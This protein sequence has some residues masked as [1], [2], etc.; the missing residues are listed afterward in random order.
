MSGF[1]IQRSKTLKC[2]LR[3]LLSC[4]DVLGVSRITE[5]NSYLGVSVSI[6]NAVRTNIDFSQVSS[7]QGKGFSL[8]Q[9]IV[10]ALGEAM[11]RYCAANIKNDR[12]NKTS[13]GLSPQG[14][15][16]D[17]SFGYAGAPIYNWI[18]GSNLSNGKPAWLPLQEVAFPYW[19]SA[20]E[21]IN[22]NA[23]TSGLAAG[24]T[25]EEAA[26][27]GLLEV[28]E[29]CVTSRFYQ[30]VRKE[31]NGKLIYPWSVGDVVAGNL[32]NEL[33]SMGCEILI[34][35]LAA[36]L[37][38]YYVAALD[39]Q[40]MSPKF[41]MAGT[42]AALSESDALRGA[43]LECVQGLVTGLQG[44]REDLSR[45]RN[46]YSQQDYTHTNV[47]YKVRDL[48]L[49]QNGIAPFFETAPKPLSTSEALSLTLTK[50]NGE[51]G[52]SVYVCDLSQQ[53]FPLSVV[54]VVA[55]SLND[56]LSNPRRYK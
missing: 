56:S 5:T 47:F 29:R 14:E 40:N 10:G 21:P 26:L 45:L 28:Y 41:M 16:P 54:K 36:L 19:R 7:T 22:I 32:I 9:A 17:L 35:R 25:F 8:A 53:N 48:L 18:L 4:R 15:A 3:S 23:Y 11:E 34:F 2:V 51:T 13:T 31:N 12:L 39:T 52:E 37:P 20:G 50:L 27:F 38:V 49:K 42:G 43:L 1:Q 46:R 33:Q 30:Y 6:V 55:P 44:S 24:S